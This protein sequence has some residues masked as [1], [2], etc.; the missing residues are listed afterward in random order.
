MLLM[1]ALRKIW[2]AKR[3]DEFNLNIII[4]VVIIVSVSKKENFSAAL[5]YV[6]WECP[7]ECRT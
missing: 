3:G 2:G 1:L 7:N 6:E 5:D 4:I